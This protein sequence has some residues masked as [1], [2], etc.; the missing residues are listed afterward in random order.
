[1]PRPTAD[2]KP[3][4]APPAARSRTARVAHG[5]VGSC[6]HPRNRPRSAG[7]VP[8]PARADREPPDELH[9]PPH[10][11]PR[12][13]PAGAARARRAGRRRRG[14]GR[15]LTPTRL[16]AAGAHARRRAP[17]AG[18]GPPQPRRPPQVAGRRHGAPLRPHAA[19]QRRH[20]RRPAAGERLRAGEPQPGVG[21]ARRGAVGR[22]RRR[23]RPGVARAAGVARRLVQAAAK[24][25]ARHAAGV[26]PRGVVGRV[27]AGGPREDG[28]ARAAADRRLRAGAVLGA[29]GPAARA[30]GRGGRC[31]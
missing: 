23:G 7:R 30:D 1:M 28:G 3:T 15:A 21:R 20:Q 9:G 11:P 19:R 24:A 16:R 4:P 31:G 22:Q 17:V 6:Y 12:D 13:R 18:R 26:V 5:S 8:P 29:V 10:P 2:C 25:R 27:P 14:V